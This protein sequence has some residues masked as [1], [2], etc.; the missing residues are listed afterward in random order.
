MWV[1]TRA[2]AVA[3]YTAPARGVCRLPVCA[4]LRQV[5]HTARRGRNDQLP[6]PHE[7]AY[8]PEPISAG[9]FRTRAGMACRFA[10]PPAKREALVMGDLHIPVRLPHRGQNLV[11][12][13]S[14]E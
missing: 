2:E 1:M 12:R 5:A 3:C 9:P 10:E 11:N 7:K 13:G 14:E 6:T 8:A 4:A